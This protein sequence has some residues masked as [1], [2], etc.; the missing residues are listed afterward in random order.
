MVSHCL[1]TVML[2]HSIWH[3]S[4]RCFLI[5]TQPHDC[6]LHQKKRYNT[7]NYHYTTGETLYYCLGGSSSTS[8]VLERSN[9][10]QVELK[11]CA[12]YEVTSLSRKKVVMKKNP[13][14]E[15]V[16]VSLQ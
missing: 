1:Q 2:H 13:A 3:N 10:A 6:I 14:Y 8:N 4:S 11:R 7:L 9:E 15:C 5:C 12:A 16:T